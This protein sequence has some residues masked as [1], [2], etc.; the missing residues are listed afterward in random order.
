[1]RR[2]GGVRL[3]RTPDRQTWMQRRGAGLSITVAVVLF[4]V[5]A[6]VLGRGAAWLDGST[7]RGLTASQRASEID[8]M[9]GYLI[10]IGAGVLAAGALL[11]TAR[12][13]QLAREGHVTDRYTKAIEQLG[14]ERLDV[15][16]GAIYA[17][18]RIMIDSA[19][20]HPT[21]VEVLSA[22]VREHAP[23]AAPGRD[24]DGSGQ[25]EQHPPLATDAQAAV[26]VLGRRP[27]GRTGRG[28]VNLTGANLRS[29]DLGGADL[30]GADLGGADLT[31]ADLSDADLSRAN[32]SGVANLTRVDLRSANLSDAYLSG[33]DLSGAYLSGADLS[34]AN[35]GG[36][37]LSRAYLGGADLSR[38]NLRGANLDDAYLGGAKLTGVFLTDEQRSVVRGLSGGGS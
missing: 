32:L 31:R 26:T 28:P 19:R 38:A 10:Q 9:R 11:Y 18:E 23:T 5:F 25:P 1:M 3:E 20:D 6:L 21:I 22:F 37:D 24:P 17:L 12:N 33:A 2:I 14:S 4:A 15:R 13:F 36:A 30:T 8:T 27:A 16:L 34:R 29:A 7:L 35:L